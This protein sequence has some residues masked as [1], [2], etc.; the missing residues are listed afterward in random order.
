[1]H[2]DQPFDVGGIFVNGI[3]V[4]TP[5]V[6]VLAEIGMGQRKSQMLN[7]TYRF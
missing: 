7:I 4:K 5:G 2:Q 6:A 1:M 3:D